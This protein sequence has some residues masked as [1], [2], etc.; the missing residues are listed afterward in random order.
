[1]ISYCN[2]N[3]YVFSM[4]LRAIFWRLFTFQSYRLQFYEF[5]IPIFFL[6]LNK[7]FYS[8]Q[9]SI[10]RTE[11]QTAEQQLESEVV[12]RKQW[13]ECKRQ[14]KNEIS[15][16]MDS[17]VDKQDLEQKIIA[18]KVMIRLHLSRITSQYR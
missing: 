12:K 1:M 11:L 13:E 15:S 6:S 10:L 4:E 14:F 7:R 18:L 5:S 17:E 3:T 16:L 2:L 9:L 8:L